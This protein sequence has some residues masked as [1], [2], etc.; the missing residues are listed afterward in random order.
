MC[1]DHHHVSRRDALRGGAVAAVATAATIAGA[2][3]AKAQDNPYAE[4]TEPALPASDM[5]IE[6][7]HTA[8][9]VTDP[10]VDFL[11]PDGVTW[12]VVGASVTRNDTV[13]N[14]ERLFKAAKARNMTVA[15]SPH[16]YFPTDHGWKFEGALEKLMHKIGMFD[17]PGALSLDGFEGSGADWMPQ[18][19]PYINDGK[20]IVTSPH[21]VY[22]NDTNDLTLQ[23]RKQ[24]VDKVILAGMSANLCTESH[25]RELIEQGFEVGVVKDATAAAMLPEGDGYLAA[26]TNFRYIANAVWTTDEVVRLIGAA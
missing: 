26:L 6:L 20:T 3:A 16:Y 12:G 21:K 23:L 13:R 18:Y 7:S 10:Q 9:V 8:L 11:S 2:S 4:P 15:V 1:D 22:G 19:K 24:R 5:T 25:M 14:I 17:R